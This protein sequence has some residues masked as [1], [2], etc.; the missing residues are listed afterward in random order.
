MAE[1]V[2]RF[3]AGRVA[4]EA[5]GRH[6]SRSVDKGVYDWTADDLGTR[7]AEWLIVFAVHFT[8]RSG[9]TEGVT[10]IRFFQVERCVGCE[11]GRRWDNVTVSALEPEGR[12][13]WEM[14]SFVKS[15]S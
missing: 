3:L 2:D 8:R 11:D 13:W 7:A 6:L 4:F 10:F 15:S 12:N 1:T 5:L 14:A 9:P